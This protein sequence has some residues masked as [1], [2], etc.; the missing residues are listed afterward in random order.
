MRQVR[1]RCGRKRFNTQPPEGGWYGAGKKRALDMA[2]QHAAAR[3]RLGGPLAEPAVSIGFNTQPPEGGWVN[4][5]RTAVERRS[6]NTQPPEGGWPRAHWLSAGGSG[7]NTQ[8]PEGGWVSCRSTASLNLAF[9]H[10]AARRR[11]ATHEA[12]KP[13]TGIVST[14][15]RPKAAGQEGEIGPV[16]GWVSTR[17][18]P[19]A[20]GANDFKGWPFA[21]VST[22]SRPKAAGTH[23]GGGQVV[24]VVSTRSR[25][26]AAG[27]AKLS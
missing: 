3:R 20:A 21:C 10:A 25:P 13:M 27:T 19:K 7:F 15:S 1:W 8:P 22:R 24:F 11:L 4:R 14:R 5:S 2:F 16:G 17:S 9:Q 6:F 18:R 23:H 12:I 26:K